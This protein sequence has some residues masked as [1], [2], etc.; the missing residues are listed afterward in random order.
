M[1]KPLVFD[2]YGT[3]LDVD[4]AARKLAPED[5][6]E[7]AARWR[8][9]QLSYSWLRSLMGRY[10][11]FWQITTESLDVTLKEMGI[12]D[13]TLRENLLNLYLDLPPYDEVVP[14]LQAYKEKGYPLAALSN[15]NPEMLDRALES[16]GI[17]SLLDATLSID[18][19]KI[20]KPDPKVYNMV[21]EHF[22]CTASDVTF[23]S[24]NNW[25]IAG[26][27]SFGFRTIWVNRGN[28]VWDALGDSPP[29]IVSSLSEAADLI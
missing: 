27:G 3:L 12:N 2:I 1:V 21:L 25:D 7:L 17:S 8:Q 22:G 13:T 11:P 9:R 14:Q 16:S 28:K 29:H 4:A 10:V 23:F 19:L 6:P 18:R 15:G 26:A 5:W 24:S 20:Y